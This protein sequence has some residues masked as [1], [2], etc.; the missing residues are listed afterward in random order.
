LSADNYPS[1]IFPSDKRLAETVTIDATWD[2]LKRLSSKTTSYGATEVLKVDVS[3]LSDVHYDNGGWQVSQLSFTGAGL[4]M[5]VEIGIEYSEY[6]LPDTI[7]AS[8]SGTALY[9]LKYHY[10]DTSTFV[11]AGI[12]LD[13]LSY[14][15]IVSYID[16]Y[17]G[18]GRYL[19]KYK[20]ETTGDLSKLLVISSWKDD[21]DFTTLGEDSPNGR[22]EI[23]YDAEGRTASFT[24]FKAKPASDPAAA[25]E[26][27]WQYQYSYEDLLSS[28][29]A[30]A[31]KLP[32]LVGELG[33][34]QGDISTAGTTLNK[35][36]Q[37]FDANSILTSFLR[38]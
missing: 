38:Q 27:A 35:L 12:K 26:I 16:N 31:A 34:T 29:Q 5:P 25:D 10:S 30:N 7:T 15:G 37:G 24:S 19:G 36:I 33:L 28:A 1:Q 13:P 9:S 18:G 22:F 2:S 3:Y 21:G 32:T 8:S 4:L 23:G 11:P 17:D 6:H 14:G 20:F